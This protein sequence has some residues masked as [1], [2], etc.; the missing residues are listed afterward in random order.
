M[1]KTIARASIALLVLSGCDAMMPTHDSTPARG[2]LTRS[3][4]ES[5]LEEASTIPSPA[6][7]AVS[8]RAEPAQSIP[9]EPEGERFNLNS[10]DTPAQ[11]F[12][13][14]LVDRTKHN[15]VV[16]PEVTGSISLMLQD[17][18]VSE[19]LEVVSEVYGYNYRRGAAGYIVY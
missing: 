9:V 7:R 15:I 3:N 11:A 18:T 16:H 19:V 14:A 13:M 5:T 12:F 8:Q 1:L 6:K 17:V 2:E 4:I 10:E